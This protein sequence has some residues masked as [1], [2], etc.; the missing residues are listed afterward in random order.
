[1]CTLSFYPKP[2]NN[3]FILTF[4]RD[5]MPNRSSVEIVKD[6]KKGLIYPKDALHGGT[7]LAIDQTNGRFTCLL[8][9]AFDIHKRQLP[10]RKSRGLVLLES[11]NYIDIRDFWHNYDLSNIEPFTMITGQKNQLLEFRWDGSIRFTRQIDGGKPKIWSSATLYNHAARSQ[12]EKHFLQFLT[13]KKAK[14]KASDLWQFHQTP[15]A[16]TPEN[17]ILMRRPLGQPSTV[18]ISQITYSFSPQTIEFQYYELGNNN[19]SHQQI[20]YG[21]ALLVY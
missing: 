7:W 3:G 2:D 6:E 14:P 8:N 20:P 15:D 17:G 18:S 21:Q 16:K 13:T 9:G 19:I 10:Y 12:R 5:E 4:N 11:F 1:M